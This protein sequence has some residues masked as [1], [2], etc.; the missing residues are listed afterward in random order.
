VLSDVVALASNDVWAV[1]Q[2]FDPQIP[3][4]SQTFTAHWDGSSWKR[5]P[6]RDT[7]RFNADGFATVTAI[8]PNDIWAIGNH[9]DGGDETLAEHWNGTAWSIVP[10]PPSFLMNAAAAIARDDV[11]AVGW[12]INTSI[13]AHWDGSRWRVV[14]SP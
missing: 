3:S 7:G 14:P 9:V 4:R 11:W 5:V 6:S 8:S 12:M 1:G 13:I 10:A 2:V